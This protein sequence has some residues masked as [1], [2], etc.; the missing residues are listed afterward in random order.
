VKKPKLLFFQWNHQRLP[1]FLHLHMQL[2]VK[3]L[4][5]FFEVIVINNDCDYK[6]VCDVHQPDLALFESGYR[7]SISKR[8]K[9]KNTSACPNVPK[10]GLHNGD[11][12]CEC[13]TGFISDMEHWGIETFFSISTTTAENTLEL[14]E[15]LFVWPNFIDSDI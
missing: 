1:K 6:Q 12:W 14:A 3:C 8:I 10:I 7:T 13:R 11:P 2:H 4:S 9:I 15:N 5:E